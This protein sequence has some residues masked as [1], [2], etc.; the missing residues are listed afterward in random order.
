LLESVSGDFSGVPASPTLWTLEAGPNKLAGAAGTDGP[1]FDVDIVSFTIPT[2]M[3]LNSI[4]IDAFED[5]TAAFIGLQAGTPWLTG[6][7]FAVEETHLLSYALIGYGS[8][9]ADLLAELHF[10]RLKPFDVPLAAGVYTLELQDIHT[11]FSYAFTFH[12]AAVPPAGIPGDFDGKNGVTAADLDK[13]RADY[14]LSGG[15]DADGDGDSD[16]NDLLIW[17]QHLGQ[18]TS[19]AAA[20]PGSA[21]VPEPAAWALAACA[22]GS[23]TT[24]RRRAG[25][26]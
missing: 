1:L 10:A 2:G 23:A 19:V 14:G 21:A 5:E 16:G 18:G 24:R 6:V 13:W 11:P 22:W 7:G 8:A 26:D 9:P 17:Q 20:S 15:S 25:R 3:Q 4:A 12:A